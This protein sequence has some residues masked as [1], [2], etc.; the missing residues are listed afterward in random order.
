MRTIKQQLRERKLYKGLNF[1]LLI[2][3]SLYSYK[4]GVNQRKA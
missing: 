2:F 3:F 4:Q 1:T